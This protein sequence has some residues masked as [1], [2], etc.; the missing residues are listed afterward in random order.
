MAVRTIGRRK[1]TITIPGGAAA[2][3]ISEQTLW[4]TDFEIH[5]PTANTSAN[6]FIGPA[7]VD[8]TYIPRTKGY[9][10]NFTHGTGTMDGEGAVLGFDLAKIYVLSATAG[11]TCIVEYMY[12]DNP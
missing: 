8:T 7:G 11:D 12:Y 3:P 1:I 6:G 5:F 2:Q 10:F 9:T 4:T